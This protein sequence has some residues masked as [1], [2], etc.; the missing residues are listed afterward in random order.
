MAP[1]TGRSA[2][3]SSRWLCS[4]SDLFVGGRFENAAG[5]STADYLARW[6]GSAWF[7]VGSNGSGDG[8]LD[9]EADV[10]VAALATAGPDLYVGGAFSDAAGIAT[11]DN[12]ARWNGAAWSGVGSDGSGD[13]AVGYGSFD[14]FLLQP[15]VAALAVSGT[16]LYVGGYFADVAGI[17]TADFVARWNGSAWSGLGSDGAGD[18]AIK[19]A[20]FVDVPSV[21]AL[22]VLGSDVIVGGNFTNAG[23]VATA[24]SVAR[25]TGA[26]WAGIGS[27]GAGNGAISPEVRA[28]VVSGT[29]LY[30]AG[31]FE[32]AGLATADHIARWDG[33]A[34]SA[35]GSN[36][37][38]NGALDDGALALALWGDDLVTG[39]LF[40]N[41]AGIA[42]AD[43]V[44]VWAPGPPSAPRSVVATPGD[45]LAL[46]EWAAPA[47]D[48]GSGITGYEATS[49]PPGAT[50][51]TAGNLWCLL[52]GLTNA[53]PYTFTVTA[54]NG[55]G[56][57]A[58]SAPSA[59]VTPMVGLLIPPKAAVVPLAAFRAATSIGVSWG[60]R[61]GSD[62]VT[63][64]D[65]RYRRA[66]WSGGFGSRVT[67]LA[68]T[69]ATSGT[70]SGVA[71]Y[72][73]CFSSRAHDAL[74]SVSGWTGETCTATPLDD[75]K[76]TRSGRWTAG[77][78][79]SYYKSTYLRSSTKGARVYRTSVVAKRL[80]IV[81]RT[82]PTCGKVRV[83]WGS[84]LLKTVNTYSAT[85]RN[86][87]VIPVSTFSSARTG[88]VTVKVYSSGKRVYVDGIVIGRN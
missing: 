46:V 21:S 41:A 82:C 49:S 80:A 43:R 32:T 56:T 6:S 87:V 67:W 63:S 53:T 38:G 74:G 2:A 20:A 39:G 79:G 73:Y 29:D 27:N 51:T 84:T 33:G 24:D 44:A 47:S 35:L 40:T 58:P 54:T 62:D 69:T 18:G 55:L 4:G 1:A 75:R 37:A 28:L 86:K 78:S 85:T 23:G 88:R 72:T 10:Y 68:G 81:V 77:T 9:G 31:G 66:K 76:L 12:L 71:G 5:V 7:G 50:C 42:T 16:D 3:R 65:V 57:G 45:G 70:Y 48:G 30:V 52:S 11:A 61:P 36:G 22:A 26:A 14:T 19:T 15:S 34:W 64:Y 59:A 83:Y 13:G 17:A 25:W 8:A 60:A